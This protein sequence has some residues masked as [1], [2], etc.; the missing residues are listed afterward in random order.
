MT[1]C[2]YSCAILL[3][4][5]Q[6]I[7]SSLSDEAVRKLHLTVYPQDR[8]KEETPNCYAQ[9]CS[10]HRGRPPAQLRAS[11]TISSLNTA[12]ASELASLLSSCPTLSSSQGDSFKT[13]VTSLQLLL[14][15]YRPWAI[16]PQIS[17]NL[18]CVRPHALHHHTPATLAPWLFLTYSGVLLPQAFCTCYSHYLEY[19]FPRHLQAYTLAFFRFL[20]KYNFR[21]NLKDSLLDQTT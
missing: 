13:S 3:H 8:S 2:S 4:P 15:P 11:S 7:S 16:W 14:I 18:L 9:A 19:S 1:L 5:S 10:I 20:L 21:R 6:V 17:S 12:T